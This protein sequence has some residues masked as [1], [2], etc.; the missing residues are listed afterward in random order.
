MSWQVDDAA[1]EQGAG[2][3]PAS[4]WDVLFRFGEEPNR[5]R[6]INVFRPD[7]IDKADELKTLTGEPSWSASVS[8]GQLI[9]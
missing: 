7:L 2:D 8:S 4:A 3:R 5:L 9:W 1:A 6:A